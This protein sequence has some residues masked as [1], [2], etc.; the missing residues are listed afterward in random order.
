MLKQ[1]QFSPI[2]TEE[3]VVLIYAGVNGFMDEIDVNQIGAFEDGL[4]DLI[5]KD[6]SHV[7]DDIRTSKSLNVD[8]EEVIKAAIQSH[9]SNFKK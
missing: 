9:S 3:Q 2:P 4:L 5:R 8:N 7:L 6:Y 1:K